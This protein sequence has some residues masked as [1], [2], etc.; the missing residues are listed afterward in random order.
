MLFYYVFLLTGFISIIVGLIFIVNPMMLIKASEL[1]NKL[2]FSDELL[3]HY[4]R[5]LGFVLFII[6]IV[7]LVISL[8][9]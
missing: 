1:S 5:F 6:I 2:I 3:V 7:L 4:S 8:E 9:Y